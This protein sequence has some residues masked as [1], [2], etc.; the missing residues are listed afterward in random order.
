[1]NSDE[2]KKGKVQASLIFEALGR[3]AEHLE[4]ALKELIEQIK[5]ESG[6]KL[7]SSKVNKSQPLKDNPNF[8]SNFAEV[9]V[10]AEEIRYIVILL[11]KYMPA[12]VEIIYPENINLP[13]DGWNDIL[14]ELARRLHG[15]DEMARIMQNEKAVLEMKLREIMEKQKEGENK[16]VD[17]KASKK[18]E[19]SKKSTNKKSSSKKKTSSKK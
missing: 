8:F 9:E 16:G 6:V 7:L 11:F 18:V 14:N 4:Q 1:M 17:K 5:T 12:H 19:S 15:Y 2:E 13:N 10:E 3:P